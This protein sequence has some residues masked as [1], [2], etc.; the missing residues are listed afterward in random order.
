MDSFSEQIVK[1]SLDA[2][3]LMIVVGTIVA[4]IALDVAAYLFVPYVFIWVLVL[5]VFG[6]YW[7]ISAQSWEVEYAVTNGDIDI[8]RIV[9]RRERKCIVRVRGAKIESLRPV[10]SGV[11]SKAFDR[12]VM[13]ARSQATATWYFTYHSKKGSTIVFF[14]PNESVL[15]ALRGGL[16]R[17][18]QIETD[19]VL[20]EM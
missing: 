6:A 2:K 13:A 20:R 14:E 11:P 12:T 18:V 16:S 19:R 15:A 9:A 4:A 7:L 1:Q 8:D 10:K 5:G 17:V 3:R